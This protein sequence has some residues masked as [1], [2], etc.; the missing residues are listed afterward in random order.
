M[1]PKAIIISCFI[2]LTLFTGCST[3]EN[4]KN[5]EL[6]F[7]QMTNM[8]KADYYLQK[9]KEEL[10][11]RRASYYNGIAQSYMLKEA[12]E[13]GLLVNINTGGKKNE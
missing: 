12:I 1:R 5:I 13:K 3:K 11:V 6:K 2:L 9:S 8:E 10:S 4:S 7:N